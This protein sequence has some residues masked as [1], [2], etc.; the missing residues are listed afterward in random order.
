MSQNSKALSTPHF[1]KSRNFSFTSHSSLPPCYSI[2][3]LHQLNLVLLLYLCFL[4]TS[5]TTIH[6]SKHT[7]DKISIWL[8]HNTT[9][10]HLQE[11]WLCWNSAS[12]TLNILFTNLP[13]YGFNPTQWCSQV[14]EDARAQHGHTTFLKTMGYCVK[15]MEATGGGGLLPQGFRLVLRLFL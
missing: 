7:A 6:Y 11:S 15:C 14:T 13:R 8:H 4:P 1:S 5:L 10:T 9:D 3:I 2:C 12:T